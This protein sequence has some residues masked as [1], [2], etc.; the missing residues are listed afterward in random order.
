MTIDKI[1]S[2]NSL[3]REQKE[4]V[5]LLS[6]GTFLEYFDLMLY[7]HMAVLLN[8]LFF[9]AGEGSDFTYIFSAIA[10]SSTFV[11]RPIGALI[12]GWLGDNIGRRFTVI[13]TTA[14]MSITCLVM[15]FLAPYS[16][17]GITATVVVTCCR[18]MQGISS[19]G[20][21]LGAE[22]YISELCK[23]RRRYFMIALVIVCSNLGGN[24]ALGISSLILSNNLNW[25]IVFFI[26]ASVALV[27]LVARTAIRE[28]P[29]FINAK[30]KLD[31]SFDVINVK[32][33]KIKE[34]AICNKKI[35]KKIIISY[36][37]METMSPIWFYI[38]YF[39]S[40]TILKTKFL[41][42]AEGII[43][44]N[45]L[46]SFA[47]TI[48]FIIICFLLKKMHPLRVMKIKTS[49]CFPFLFFLPYLYQNVSTPQELLII[50]II[51]KFLSFDGFATVPVV[52][53]FFPVLKR[54]T[55]GAFIY[56]C[57]KAI[58]YIIMSFGIEIFSRNFGTYGILIILLPFSIGY[59]F[60]RNYL[61]KLEK[62]NGNYY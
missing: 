24:A 58:M 1:K 5:G 56:S 10:F 28:T 37:F 38:G 17:I 47:V 46:I 51:V 32:K 48:N 3:T 30:L 15:A 61:E 44:N 8:E 34:S 2:Q 11:F 54:F 19:M 14:I 50:N 16:Q 25:R 52:L 36:F 13:V 20:E 62:A 43:F 23:D 22:L 12:I 40:A 55:Y 39:Y 4:A 26:G 29:D 59:A 21:I 41:M 27:G 42:P 31:N 53:S 6:I 7:V 18:I 9:P 57:S 49:I 33:T 60:S 45:L 35:D